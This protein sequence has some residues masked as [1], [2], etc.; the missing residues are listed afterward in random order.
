VFGILYVWSVIKSGIPDA[1][2]WTHADKALPYSV[3]AVTFS[4]IMM[5]AGMLQDR[6]GPKPVIMLG[7]L[8]AGLGCVAAGM[9]GSSLAAYVAGFGF[10]TGAGVGFGYSALTP[11][12]IKWF[13]EEKTGLVAGIVVAGSGLAPVPL[14]PLTQWL[15]S[16]FSKTTESGMVEL[17]ISQTMVTLGCGIWL[18]SA[19]LVWFIHNPPFGF[20]PGTGTSSAEGPG[21]G[22][23]GVRK[24]LGTR[25]FW[26]LYP[27]YFSGAS[28]GL[29]FISVAADLGRQVLGQWAFLTVVALALGNTLGRVLAGLVS[30]RIGRQLTLFFQFLCQALAI[31]ILF[32]MSAH[33]AGSWKGTLIVVF[34]IG[35][36]YGA[37]LTIFPA[38][39]KDYFGMMNFGMNYGCLF[40][41]FGL[42]GMV[43]PWLNGFIRDYTGRADLSYLM[44]VTM[45]LVSSLLALYS[46]Y[47]GMPQISKT[48]SKT[49]G[50]RTLFP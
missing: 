27:M 47:L 36:N 17:G 49:C 32:R 44:M 11:A 24:M 15:L 41:A 38:V 29:V 46:R 50:T 12:A 23:V 35:M 45:L 7:G 18:A 42:A 21:R 3:M 13:P 5:P 39:C 6:Y 20:V 4:V 19:C 33:G 25:Q 43:M 2:G 1:W 40:T 48:A 10:L 22:N 8:L 34:L 30:D 16:L 26:L 37:N 9:G 14:A 31:F 28:A